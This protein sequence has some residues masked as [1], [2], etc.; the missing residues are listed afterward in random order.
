M[1]NGQTN[2]HTKQELLDHT[3]R[4]KMANNV[5]CKYHTCIIKAIQ[6]LYCLEDQ[7]LNAKHFIHHFASLK[8]IR[9]YLL[10]EHPSNWLAVE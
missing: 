3:D 6:L 1:S 7:A 5:T 8:R 9:K 2:G 4:K 10:G